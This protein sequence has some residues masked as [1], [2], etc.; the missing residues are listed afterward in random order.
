MKFSVNRQLLLDAVQ[1]LS[2]AVSPKSPTPVL[3]GILFKADKNQLLMMA[4]NLEMGMTKSL[5]VSC[6]KSG[7]T[8]LNAR[9]LL[10]ILKRLNEQIID[11]QIDEKMMCHIVSGT[12]GFDIAGMSPE[13]FPEMPS[14][15][16]DGVLIIP[17][18]LLKNMVKQTSFAVSQNE[19]SRP[20]LTG[21]LCEV[22]ENNLRLV[23]IDGS[24]LAIR[25]AQ[26]KNDT[27]Q[28][29]IVSGKAFSEAVKTLED[30][31]ENITIRVGKKHICFESDGYLMISR[32]I[33]GE[34][35][36]Y[37]RSIPEEHQT[38]VKI[39]NREFA[40]IIE[41]ISLIINDQ[42]KNA[43][44]CTF[45][46]NKIIFSCV[47]AVGKAKDELNIA[48][49]GNTF[50]I[51]FNSKFMLDALKAC[52]CDEAVLKFNGSTSAIVI[53]PVSGNEFLHL[54]MPMRLR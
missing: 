3:E 11:V 45:E 10:E 47:S 27:D 46:E 9:L 41:R 25:N 43:V 22:K 16:E 34:F 26:I 23:A 20:V 32:L 52:E 53:E 36:D 17:Q 1:N 19:S 18:G 28:K 15:K 50:E 5:S 39:N 7:G 12:A 14:V 40:E 8:V 4:Y 51:G 37:E 35:I 30:K 21:I 44:R 42:I 24:R 33:E 54:V 2:R 13:D 6:E 31:D 38:S 49:E 29:F 48:L